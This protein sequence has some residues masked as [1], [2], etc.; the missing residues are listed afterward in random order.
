M[1][2]E[3][4]LPI[5]LLPGCVLERYVVRI[6]RKHPLKKVKVPKLAI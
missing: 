6:E 3:K 1:Q 4:E 2:D 5:P